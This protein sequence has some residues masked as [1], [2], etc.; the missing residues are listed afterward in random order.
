MRVSTDRLLGVYPGVTLFCHSMVWRD[1]IT[2]LSEEPG[3]FEPDHRAVGC[4]EGVSRQR[5][6][7]CR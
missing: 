5:R 3:A 1:V 6:T 4:L 2:V 7:G